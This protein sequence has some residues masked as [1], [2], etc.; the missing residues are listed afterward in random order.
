MA[1]EVP[2][3]L[4]GNGKGL[5]QNF[6]EWGYRVTNGWFFALL[7]FGFCIVLLIST[8]RFGMPRSFGFAAF[9]GMIGSTF[10]AIA[11]LLSWGVASWFILTGFVGMGVLILNER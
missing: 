8:Q 5:F 2:S 11:G 10:L 4:V 9:V 6:F 1:F 7:L 3:D